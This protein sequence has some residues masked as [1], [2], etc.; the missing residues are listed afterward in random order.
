MLSSFNEVTR[1]ISGNKYVPISLIV[2]LSTGIQHFLTSCVSELTTEEGKTFCNN[3]L[4]STKQHLYPYESRTI[5]KI[6]TIL[7]SRFKKE[8]FQSPE[9]AA[10]ASLLLEQEM[11]GFLNKNENVLTDKNVERNSNDVKNTSIFSFFK[12]RVDNKVKSIQTDVIITKR[13]YLERSNAPEDTDSLTIWKFSGQ[14]LHPLGE[15]AKQYFCIPATSVERT[16][17]TAGQIVSD[18]R[19][20]LN[21]TNVNMLTFLH[22]NLTFDSE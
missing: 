10:N 2:P 13:Q 15:L 22:K 19:S 1:K 14:D 5:T 16:F 7:D 18:R 6:A 9:N 11:Y 4:I 21:P 8:A 12:E 17:S 3:L 20:R